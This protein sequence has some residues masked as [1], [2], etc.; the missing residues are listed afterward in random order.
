MSISVQDIVQ[1]RTRYLNAAS[2]DAAAY[3]LSRALFSWLAQQG[4]T[5]A[6]QVVE[7]DYQIGTSFVIADAP[8]K[9]YAIILSKATTTAASFKGTDHASTGSS[10]AFAVG[11]TQNSIGVADFFY[12]KGLPMANGFTILSNTTMA[13]STT[14]AAGDGARGVVLLGRP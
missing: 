4:G 8:C 3:Q 2:I 9:V 7:F 6:L 5:P 14:S 13:G 1:A 10:T 12:P 11:Q